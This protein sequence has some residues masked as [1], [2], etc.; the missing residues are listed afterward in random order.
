ML[1]SLAAFVPI[2]ITLHTFL[3]TRHTVRAAPASGG[4]GT[5]DRTAWHAQTRA[6]PTYMY[7]C[8]TLASLLL[9]GA[10][11][12]A[13]ARSV[14]A[15][16][17]AHAAAVTFDV[18]VVVANLVVWI[19]AAAVYRA[20]KNLNGVPNDLW[21]WA[22]S[23][24]AEEI[25]R[26]FRDEVNFNSLCSVQTGSWVVG[27]V[28]VVGLVLGAVIWVFVFKRRKSKTTLRDSLGRGLLQE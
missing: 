17:R 13:Y 26:A 4:D 3:A 25:Q 6:W 20:E 27:V 7:F 14:R 23:A 2:A 12:L 24:G 21:G 18:V 9:N 10:M 28:Q 16:N 1:L 15:A 8:V 22:C 5:V 19:V 11:L